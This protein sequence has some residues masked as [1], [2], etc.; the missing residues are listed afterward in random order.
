[1]FLLIAHKIVPR[2]RFVRIL[3]CAQDW[4]FTRKSVPDLV[5]RA[6]NCARFFV[7]CA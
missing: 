6:L 4:S 1:M 7:V 2:S 5:V 3:D